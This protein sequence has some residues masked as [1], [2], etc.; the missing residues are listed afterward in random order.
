MSESYKPES[1]NP[2]E[3]IDQDQIKV[4]RIL[5]GPGREKDL[6][7]YKKGW[8][9]QKNNPVEQIVYE[10]N[11]TSIRNAENWYET[12]AAK[13]YSMFSDAF[14]AGTGVREH[15][16]DLVDVM[17]LMRENPDLIPDDAWKKET[18]D[19]PTDSNPPRFS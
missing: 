9:D 2:F 13:R 19:E 5:T 10:K 8:N 12:G 4:P 11:K 14:N 3:L 7:E 18:D 17:G 6:E 15:E 1:H 16:K